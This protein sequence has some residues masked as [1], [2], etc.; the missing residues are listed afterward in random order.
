MSTDR[1]RLYVCKLDSMRQPVHATYI[2]CRYKKG[3]YSPVAVKSNDRG[4]P[5]VTY[6]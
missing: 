2:F 3:E 4:E 1:S 6:R 5:A